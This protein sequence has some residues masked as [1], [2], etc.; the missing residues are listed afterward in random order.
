MKQQKI[1]STVLTLCM[2]AVLIA[3]GISALSGGLLLLQNRMLGQAEPNTVPDTV[4]APELP[5]DSL[6]TI[7]LK[8]PYQE[9][10]KQLLSEQYI[11][12]EANRLCLEF[13]G[14]N[15]SGGAI[16]S[17][18]SKGYDGSPPYLP[19]YYWQ[20]SAMTDENRV[21]HFV[22]NAYNGM[23][24]YADM[25]RNSQSDMPLL[26][27]RIQHFDMDS[28]LIEKKEMIEK[29]HMVQKEQAEASGIFSD[30]EIPEDLESEQKA[31]QEDFI[32]AFSEETYASAAEK[33]AGYAEQLLWFGHS[34]E[35]TS[36]SSKAESEV[37]V[38]PTDP[39]GILGVQTVDY[40]EDALIFDCLLSDGGSLLIEV[41]AEGS[42]RYGQRLTNSLYEIQ[43]SGQSLNYL[44]N[45]IENK[46]IDE[47]YFMYSFLDYSYSAGR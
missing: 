35:T 6:N 47:P 14:Q 46:H 39:A 23:P 32:Y 8:E 36:Q 21:L 41:D 1:K 16:L 19:D 13:Y 31:M 25:D 2:A 22:F 37:S 17:L 3:A 7:V 18:D 40:S 43:T 26:Q 4:N 15:L 5:A 29:L 10:A 28:A 9:E 34:E 33:A 12:S 24:L 27:D 44:R 30:T 45:N 11:L 38:T 20:G 42:F